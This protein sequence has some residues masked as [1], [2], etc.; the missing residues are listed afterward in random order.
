MKIATIQLMDGDDVDRVCNI[1]NTYHYDI[2]AVSPRYIVDA[3]SFLGLLGIMGC[4]IDI[5]MHSDSQQQMK[6]L[7]T[8]LTPWITTP[9]FAE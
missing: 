1:A 8:E 9:N 6:S 4:P 7:L 3:K 2:D 5:H